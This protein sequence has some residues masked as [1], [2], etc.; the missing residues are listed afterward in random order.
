[1]CRLQL[2]AHVDVVSGEWTHTDAAVGVF[3]DSLYEYLL[4]GPNILLMYQLVRGLV[5]PLH[6]LIM[7]TAL[8][9]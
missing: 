5:V 3:V 7:H 9:I 6:L 4:K 1:M 2:G 8:L